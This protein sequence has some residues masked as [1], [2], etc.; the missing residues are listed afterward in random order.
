LVNPLLGAAE[1]VPSSN[2]GST[3]Q[4]VPGVTTWCPG[5]RLVLRHMAGLSSKGSDVR[6][7]T[8]AQV[9]PRAGRVQSVQSNLWRWRSA[10]K[11]RWQPPEAKDQE[12]AG[13][14]SV[15]RAQDHINVLELRAL[16]AATRWALRSYKSIGLSTL[17]LTDSRVTMGVASK[18]RSSSKVLQRQ[19]R[20][21]AAL[22][23]GGSCRFCTGFIRSDWNPADKASRDFR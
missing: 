21:L 17:R 7:S 6:L 19:L 14:T 5:Q 1:V 12:T 20:K 4:E 3:S 9:V 16:V 18:Y 13:G 11:W 2:H 15:A 8:G 10:F 22:E 23:L